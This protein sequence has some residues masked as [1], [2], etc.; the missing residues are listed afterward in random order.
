MLMKM[1]C[2]FLII[3]PLSEAKPQKVTNKWCADVLCQSYHTPYDNMGAG[4]VGYD[5]VD[6]DPF[7]FKKDPGK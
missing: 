2:C 4:L 6:S 7:L 5:P 1:L 3:Y